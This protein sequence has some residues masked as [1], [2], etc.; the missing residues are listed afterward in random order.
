MQ[1]NN[2]IISTRIFVVKAL[3]NIEKCCGA[4]ICGEVENNLF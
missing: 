1:L 2:D 4:V 3:V